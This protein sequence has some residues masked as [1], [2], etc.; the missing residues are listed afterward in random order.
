MRQ[1]IKA[2]LDAM[3][4]GVRER[5]KALRGRAPAA[6]VEVR[7]LRAEVDGLRRDL[8]ELRAELDET[9]R[10]SL[11]VAQLTDLVEERLAQGARR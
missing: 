11:R 8:A 1:A 6:T 5:A 9:R 10:D 2:G 3:P 4:D 7:D